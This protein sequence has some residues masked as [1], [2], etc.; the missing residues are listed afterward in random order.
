MVALLVI[1]TLSNCNKDNNT[2][3]SLAGGITGRYSNGYI[4]IVVNK[5]D[6]NTVSVSIDGL[7]ENFNSTTVNTATTFTLNKVVVTDNADELYQKSGYGSC[8]NGN[9]SVTVEEM[10]VYRQIQDTT[11]TSFT[12]TGTKVQ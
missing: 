6:D 11:R 12:Y 3:T 8:S 5:V 10:Q 1:T 2:D 4:D 9:I 7:G